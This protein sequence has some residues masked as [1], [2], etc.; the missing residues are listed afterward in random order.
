MGL[1]SW[2]SCWNV[3]PSSD[4]HA[5]VF[6]SGFGPFHSGQTC[7]SCAV[8]KVLDVKAVAWTYSLMVTRKAAL[9]F[10]LAAPALCT[11]YFALQ[12]IALRQLEIGPANSFSDYMFLFATTL[13]VL[14]F[15][16]Y[17]LIYRPQKHGIN[18]IAT[19]C[20]SGSIL[21]GFVTI[22]FA[23]EHDQIFSFATYFAHILL[24]GSDYNISQY[25]SVSVWVTIIA[26]IFIILFTFLIFFAIYI[27]LYSR[28]K[29]RQAAN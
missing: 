4:D 1:R 18:R 25:Y 29:N 24:S 28:L 11:L 16:T 15:F 17:T 22:L 3:L 26:R 6:G 9:A 7:Q 14:C 2:G 19:I 10:S 20:L 13:F 27:G 23:F 8:L 12:E 5:P 21:S